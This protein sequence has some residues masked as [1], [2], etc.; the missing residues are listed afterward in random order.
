M[1]VSYKFIR[2]LVLCQ[3]RAMLSA[4]HSHSGHPEGVQER[5][6]DCSPAPLKGLVDRFVSTS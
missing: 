5:G 1:A 6:C 2:S 4:S 3:G